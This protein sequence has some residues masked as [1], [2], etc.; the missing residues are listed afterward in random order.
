MAQEYLSLIKF[1]RGTAAQRETVRFEEGEP[2]WEID[3]RRLFVGVGDNTA[4]NV[5]DPYGGSLSGNL[6]FVDR[7]SIDEALTSEIEVTSDASF[8]GSLPHSGD[9]LFKNGHLYTFIENENYWLDVSPRVDGVTMEYNDQN[10]LVA[11]IPE[12]DFE[13]G[14]GLTFD[15]GTLTLNLSPISPIFVNPDDNCVTIR[16]NSISAAYLSNSLFSSGAVP[17]GI[18]VP[19]G[20]LT[21]LDGAVTSSKLSPTLLSGNITVTDAGALTVAADNVSIAF[22]DGKLSAIGAKLGDKSDTSTLVGTSRYATING[23]ITERFATS[24]VGTGLSVD[25]NNDVCVVDALVAKDANDTILGANVANVGEISVTDSPFVGSPDITIDEV[26]T[27]GG[28]RSE[29]T[30]TINGDEYPFVSAGMVITTFGTDKTPFAVPVFALLPSPTIISF[31]VMNGGAALVGTDLNG[32]SIYAKGTVTTGENTNVVTVEAPRI[33]FSKSTNFNRLQKIVFDHSAFITGAS[34]V[35]PAG[36]PIKL[37]IKTPSGTFESP[38][39]ITIGTVKT[40]ETGIVKVIKTSAMGYKTLCANA[41]TGGIF[42][43]KV[44]KDNT[45]EVELAVTTSNII[46]ISTAESSFNPP[47][48]VLL[49][50][51]T[52]TVTE[53]TDNDWANDDYEHYITYTVGDKTYEYPVD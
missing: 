29:F 23:A 22:V 6:V 51:A 3:R 10:Q 47:P 53:N 37:V 2:V 36:T 14:G 35:F 8:Y 42:G 38:D 28:T 20:R 26:W 17:G 5:S 1:K 52:V 31:I 41:S 18:S 43:A 7:D 12:V 45:T 32:C 19:G 9:I 16:N 4:S 24:P 34:S 27:G 13:T 46:N 49:H 33:S 21:L 11:V 39:P 44:I 25:T 48:A 15:A 40:L 50:C 30:G